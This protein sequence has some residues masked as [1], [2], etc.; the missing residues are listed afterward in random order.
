MRWP[1]VRNIIFHDDTITVRKKHI[2]RICELI[3]EEGLEFKWK[4]WS[5]LDVLDKDLLQLMQKAGCVCLLCGVESGTDRGLELVGKKLDLPRLLENTKMI[6]ESGMACLYSF[7]AGIPGESPEDSLAT[8]RLAR[9]LQSPNAVA[10]IYFGTSIFP[11]TAFCKDLE[12][13]YGPIDWE[14]PAPSIRPLFGYD[15]FGNPTAPDIGHPTEVVEQ[16]A[17]SMGL[18]PAAH[19]GRSAA[20][21]APPHIVN[22]E[23][24]RFARQWSPYIIPQL[25]QLASVIASVDPDPAARVL[26]LSGRGKESLLA[27][28]LSDR[29]EDLEE[30]A[31]PEQ[32][33]QGW[34]EADNMIEET[35]KDL[36]ASGFRLVV[37][38]NSLAGLRDQ[39]RA[40]VLSQL[41]RTLSSDG[42]ALFFLQNPDHL[43]M[44]AARKLRRRSRTFER[45]LSV[46]AF[47]TALREAGFAID[48]QRAA[49]IALPSVVANQLPTSVFNALGGLRLP[50]SLGVWSVLVCKPAKA[51]GAVPI[52]PP[53]PIGQS[54]EQVV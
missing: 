34:P 9:K 49:G 16:L 6:Q 22:P 2:R 13:E 50:R 29:F 25:E 1:A 43:A 44:R 3:L 42:T 18:P 8:V 30:L 41:R 38:L 24:L 7:I 46:A 53:S 19:L 47:C 39:A 33:L 51:R 15:P 17:A 23:R 21:D 45:R 11:G 14:D 52:Q 27:T 20:R 37:D 28:A 12:E 32:V 26:S 54:S 40:R 36:P 4:A 10:N 5:R 48:G 35:F 31:L